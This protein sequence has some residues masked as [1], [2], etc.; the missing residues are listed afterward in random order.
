MLY[1]VSQRVNFILSLH[2]GERYKLSERGAR[3]SYPYWCEQWCD[4]KHWSLTNGI[5]TKVLL[6]LNFPFSSRK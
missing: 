4:S 3:M 2:T 6:F 5:S 1:L